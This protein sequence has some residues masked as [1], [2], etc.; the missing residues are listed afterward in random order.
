[1]ANIV[2]DLINDI[3]AFFKKRKG[4]MFYSEAEFQQELAYFLRQ[5]HRNATIHLEYPLENLFSQK[6]KE[7]IDI[8]VEENGEFVPIE[9]KYKTKKLKL[10][11]QIFG[12]S[13][14]IGLR[15]QLATPD[16]RCE[17]WDDVERIESIK[18]KYPNVPGG[19]VVVLT[20]EPGFWKN[21]GTISGLSVKDGITAKPQHISYERGELNREGEYEIKWNDWQT[22]ASQHPDEIKRTAANKQFRY[23]CLKI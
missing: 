2:D 20:N 21:D 18:K 5:R 10:E 3:H 9:L 17:I 19:I 15:E 6:E 12:S 14:S 13:E 1:M 4:M 7:R 22:V 16:N 8:V 11:E 23:L